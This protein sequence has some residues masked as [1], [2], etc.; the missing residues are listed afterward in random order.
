M[1]MIEEENV[2]FNDVDKCKSK[3]VGDR[4]WE[5]RKEKNVKDMWRY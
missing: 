3:F 5:M 2:G 4:W 1:I